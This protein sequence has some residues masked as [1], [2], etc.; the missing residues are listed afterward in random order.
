MST[1]D[2]PL[3]F[4]DLESFVVVPIIAYQPIPFLTELGTT[5]LLFDRDSTYHYINVQA[6]AH[7]PSFM[8]MQ[9]PDARIVGVV[10]NDHIGWN[11]TSTIVVGW[12]QYVGISSRRIRRVNHFIDI[13]AAETLVDDE[14]IVPMEMHGVGGVAVVDIVVHNDAD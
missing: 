1:A 12:L 7:M 11:D 5:I 9:R 8:T 2:S 10:L 14:E 13:I 4:G 6:L 3:R